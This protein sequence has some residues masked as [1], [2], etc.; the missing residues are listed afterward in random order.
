MICMKK[1]TMAMDEER[2]L[3]DCVEDEINVKI[4]KDVQ[5]QLG[6]KFIQTK[7]RTIIHFHHWAQMFRVFKHFRMLHGG[8]HKY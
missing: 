6:R 1:A 4:L 8:N 2:D 7:D 3:G 5:K